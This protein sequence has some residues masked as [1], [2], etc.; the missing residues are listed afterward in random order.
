MLFG[1]QKIKFIF[2][3]NMSNNLYDKSNPKQVD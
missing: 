1:D 3:S 2:E